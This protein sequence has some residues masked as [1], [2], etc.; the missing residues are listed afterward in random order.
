MGQPVTRWQ[1][2]SKNPDKTADF[3][4]RLFGWNVSSNNPLGYREVET[5][6]P[7]GIDGGIWPSPEADDSRP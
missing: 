6:A 4:S 1:I 2:L 7:A 3:Y 5:G